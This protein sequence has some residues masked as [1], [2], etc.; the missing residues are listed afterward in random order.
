ML[1]REK[2]QEYFK[3]KIHCSQQVLGELAEDLGY[4]REEAYRIANAFAG[5][6]SKGDSCGTFTAALMAIGMRYGNST[7]G[8][9]QTD[10]RCIEKALQFREEFVRRHGSTICRELLDY[11]FTYP[12]QKQAA[13]D[14][15]KINEVCPGLVMDAIEIFH[16]LGED[17]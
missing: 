17:E 14:S 13:R 2:S 16:Q 1:D 4:E 10:A 12:E 11:D 8:D 15:G 6:M 3:G 9:E 7:C 5:G